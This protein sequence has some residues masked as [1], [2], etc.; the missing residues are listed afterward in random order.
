MTIDTERPFCYNNGMNGRFYVTTSSDAQRAKWQ[1]LFGVDALPV[2]SPWPHEAINADGVGVWY[3]RLDPS[4]MTAPQLHRLA[5][6][7]AARQQGVDYV[8][9]LDDIRLNGW[10]IDGTHCTIQQPTEQERPSAVS[11][12]TGRGWGGL[13]TAAS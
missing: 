6:H 8:A 4:R 12:F 2:R 9:I 3:Y 11:L 10:N 1:R 5:A 13:L 7:V